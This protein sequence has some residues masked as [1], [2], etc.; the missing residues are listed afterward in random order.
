MLI[1]D[2]LKPWCI[3][4][5]LIPIFYGAVL[6][7][8]L[9]NT[10]YWLLLPVCVIVVLVYLASTLNYPLAALWPAFACIFL[11]SACIGALVDQ[12][13]PYAIVPVLG[14]DVEIWAVALVAIGLIA[15]DVRTVIRMLPE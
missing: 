15:W 8:E 7:A 10:F 9:P 11:L 13:P 2:F 4:A 6:F 5:G 1:R 12:L 3:I 14:A